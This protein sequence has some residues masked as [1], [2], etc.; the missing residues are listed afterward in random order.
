[1]TGGKLRTARVKEVRARFRERERDEVERI[2]QKLRHD[3]PQRLLRFE[4][5][6]LLREMD[7]TPSSVGAPSLLEAPHRW[8]AI[9]YWFLADGK[10]DMTLV[11]QV[12]ADVAQT[13]D[14]TAK[15][16]E[17]YKNEYKAGALELLRDVKADPIRSV[18]AIVQTA[19]GMAAEFRKLDA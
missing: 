3:P 14:V 15:T 8:M 7:N 9:H 2:K 6:L 12:I 19:E 18:A 4:A 5:D 10:E 17:K 11:K 13:W 16:I 1:M